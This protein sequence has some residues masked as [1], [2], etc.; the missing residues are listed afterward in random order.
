MNL[1]RDIRFG[2]RLWRSSPGFAAVAALTL[3]L[4]IGA[5]TAIFSVIYAAL[6]EPMPYPDPDQLVMLWSKFPG[7]RGSVSPGDYLDWKR[8]NTVFQDVNAWSGE[9]FNLATPEQ[10]EQVNAAAV[11]P[12]FYRMTGNKFLMGRDFLPEEGEVGKDHAVVLTHRLWQRL[13]SD[14]NILRKQLRLNSEPYTVVGVFAPGT[15]DRVPFGLVVPLAFRP[16]QLNHDA[17]W[18]MTMGR[19]KPGVSLS[20]AQADADVIASRLAQ[21]YPDSNR[22][23]GIGVDPLHDDFV[24]PEVRRTLW[25]LMAAV[26]LVLLIACVNVANLL[27]ARA[28][29]RQH[30]VAVR[31][32]LGASRRQVFGQFLS[33]SLALAGIGGSLGAA[34]AFA[35]IKLFINVMPPN[36]LPSEADVR[37]SVPVLLF[38]LIATTISGVLF[39][40]APAWQASR[41]DLNETLKE[42]GRTFSGHGRHRLRRSLVIAEFA[43]ALTLL[44]SAGLAIHSLWNVARVDPGFR[45]DHI[46]TFS[47]PVPEKHF[48]QPEQI[49]SFYR[50][51]L[52]KMQSLPGISH[53]EAGT[54][55]PLQGTQFGLAFNIVG[56]EMDLGSRPGAQFG[57]VTPDF[58]QTFD[59]RI[60]QGRAFT[61]QDVAGGIP[62]AIVNE[63]F[64]KQFL[65][66]MDPLRQ[67]IST[68]KMTPGIGRL[69]PL[70]EWQIVGVYHNVRSNGLHVE[71]FPQIDVPFYQS[72]WPQA[73]VAVRT[74]G[75]PELMTKSIAAAVH[76]IAPDLALANLQTMEQIASESLV[77]DRFVSGLYGAFAAVALLLAA[78]GIYGVMAFMVTQRTHEIGLRIALGAGR[79][80]LLNTVLR[81]GCALA[82]VGLAIGLGG[83]CLVGRAM[84]S[85]LYGV[86]SVDFVAFGAVSIILLASALLA[87]YIPARRAAKVDPMVALRYE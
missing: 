68:A 85:T 42:G 12:G 19:L 31:A 25:L 64:V 76:S 79:Q 38:T 47:L 5:T 56:H 8:Q 81:E 50:Q 9:T 82:A 45:T 55:L 18:L 14:R 30:D 40:C 71:E 61:D 32:S 65:R 58:F 41:L 66:G 1:W 39:G 60:S 34:L 28:T 35:M 52:E 27:L 59:I 44:A 16:D 57:M 77:S 49:V 87:C 74:S 6:F 15:A 46:L 67:K 43:L 84:Q 29:A 63:A 75:D 11:T 83:A 36:T 13:G 54:F 7:G 2:F 72:P 24:P 4:G 53:A 80:Q 26:G 23:R 33:E 73:S 37:L 51:M 17:H 3:A 20:Q 48:S 70:V 69:G 10:P 22:N 86:G 62:V 21:E 78:I